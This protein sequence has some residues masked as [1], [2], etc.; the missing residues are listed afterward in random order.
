MRLFSVSVVFLHEQEQGLEVS[1]LR[2]VAFCCVGSYLWCCE[3]C[4]CTTLSSGHTIRRFWGLWEISFVYIHSVC[5]LCQYQF[6]YNGL[7]RWNIMSTTW[8]YSY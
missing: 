3:L 7:H 4:T 5:E 2:G 1:R 6:A 8:R